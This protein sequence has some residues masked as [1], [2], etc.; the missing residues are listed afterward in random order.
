MIKN[1]A[2]TKLRVFIHPNLVKKSY[3]YL[4]IPPRTTINKPINITNFIP[5][6]IDKNEVVF[7]ELVI[8][9][10]GVMIE[11][12]VLKERISKDKINDTIKNCNHTNVESWTIKGFIYHEKK[13]LIVSNISK[14]RLVINFI[15]VIIYLF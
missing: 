1:I 7:I 9:K 13:R 3:L 6:K 5:I 2:S 14:L 15:I 10:M 12:K 11:F 8:L 4:G